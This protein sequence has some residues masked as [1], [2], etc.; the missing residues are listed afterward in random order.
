MKQQHQFISDADVDDSFVKILDTTLVPQLYRLVKDF[1][2]HVLTPHGN[3]CK[4][5][6]SP[7]HPYYL[8][9]AQLYRWFRNCPI[10]CLNPKKEGFKAP[11]EIV[12]LKKQI[13][14]LLW[15]V[16]ILTCWKIRY[17]LIVA[18]VVCE[19]VMD[20][21]LPWKEKRQRWRSSIVLE[22]QT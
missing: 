4:R 2:L 13:I 9:S 21:V 19:I 15:K 18:S 11:S 14:L 16:K 10:P 12:D 3:G 8:A 7:F 1:S 6:V 20:R 5:I 22:A 17:I